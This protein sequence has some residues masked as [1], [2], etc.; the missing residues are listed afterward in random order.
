[1]NKDGNSDTGIYLYLYEGN[2]LSKVFCFSI[3]MGP[4]LREKGWIEQ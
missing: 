2:F 4:I 3:F 1:M